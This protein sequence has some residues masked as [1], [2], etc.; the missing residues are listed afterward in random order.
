MPRQKVGNFIN[1]VEQGKVSDEEFA[2][3]KRLVEKRSREAAQEQVTVTPI[4]TV[5]YCS[6]SPQTPEP[7]SDVCFK[8]ENNKGKMDPEL[9]GLESPS[10]GTGL[11]TP[12]QQCPR[13]EGTWETG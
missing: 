2:V 9:K 10:G 3:L 7:S 1:A 4:D 12:G 8:L 13:N 11:E 5:Q 6:R